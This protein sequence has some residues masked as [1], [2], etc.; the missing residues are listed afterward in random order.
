M[1]GEGAVRV[2]IQLPEPLK[3]NVCSAFSPW[4]FTVWKRGQAKASLLWSRSHRKH[5][6]LNICCWKKTRKYKH[7]LL[8]WF[9]FTGTSVNS[10]LGSLKLGDDLSVVPRIA[11]SESSLLGGGCRISGTSPWIHQLQVRRK[12]R[13]AQSRAGIYPSCTSFS[14]R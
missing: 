11:I 5:L 7:S 3:T 2:E 10:G 13:P 9:W 1:Q 8:V 6:L 14:G 12:L 4:V